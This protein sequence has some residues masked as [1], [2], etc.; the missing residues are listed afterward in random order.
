MK[1]SLLRL[2]FLLA[3]LIPMGLQNSSAIS[4]CPGCT[5]QQTCGKLNEICLRSCRANP[6]CVD[7]CSDIYT[8]CI[9]NCNP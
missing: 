9:D 8:N 6:D 1:R 2:G 5:C 7:N 3:I 4:I